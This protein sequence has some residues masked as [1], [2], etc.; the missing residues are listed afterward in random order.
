VSSTR[1]PGTG[2]VID[3]WK[4]ND[5]TPSKLAT[6]RWA[7]G[8]GKPQGVG[9]RWRGWY[10]GDDGKTR[11]ERF[12]TEAEAE[13]WANAARG[14]VVTNQW[15]SPD[16]G[17][18]A[19]ANV[20]EQ[21]F[22]IKAHC[23]PKTL[24]GYRSILDTLVL[25]RWG[26]R[27]LK[28]ITYGELSAWL[29]GLSVD[30]SQAGT[31]LSASRVIQT[32]QLMGAVCKYAV[33]AGLASKNVA[34]EIERRHDLPKTGESERHYLTHRQL[35]DLARETG[36]FEARTLVLGYCGL[37]FG[38]AAAL[39]RKDIGD[40]EI[41]VRSSATYVAG[42]GILETGTKTNRS[43][44]VPVPAP[45]WELVKR[46]LPGDREDL[47]F[48]SRT[49][50]HL[51]NHEYRRAFDKALAVVQT[52]AKTKRQQEIAENGEAITPDFPYITPQYLRH[53]CASLAISA[54]ANVKVVQRMLGHAT[55]AM[56]L[57]LYGHLMSDD[58]A[59]VA[60]ALGKAMAAA[61]QTVA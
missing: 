35:L 33:K 16:L 49:G 58:L 36:R 17:A 12:R 31:G 8:Q 24:A 46:Q 61:Q 32:H 51:S 37:R 56:T 19:F 52:T 50:G 34:A 60:A 29:S 9:K 38:E 22:R 26:E 21:W 41:T 5:G 27:P 1:T 14:K 11:T 48:P 43:R 42:Q 4:K 39:R 40:R 30:G 2:G 15:V 53:T 54:G 18:D 57:D 6:G 10:V 25:P 59:G 7:E 23:K 55:A 44:H 47:V 3:L 45:I 13:G 28:A 20:A